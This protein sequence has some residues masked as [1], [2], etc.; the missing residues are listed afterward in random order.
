[1]AQRSAENYRQWNEDISG[2]L[3]F[4]AAATTS[5][6]KTVRN[7]NTTIFV[8]RVVCYITTD[9]AQSLTIQDSSGKILCSV[10]ASPGVNTRWDFPLGGDKGVP[11]TEGANL[12]ATFSAAGLAGTV[13]WEGYQRL[14][15]AVAPGTTN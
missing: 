6:I 3:T 7:A 10:T 4:A 12:T 9:A 15:S 1:M 11:C 5:T 2:S 14:T 8:Q 13:S